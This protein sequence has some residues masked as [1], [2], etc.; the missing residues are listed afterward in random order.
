MSM[1]AI[2]SAKNMAVTMTGLSKDALHVYVGLIV[3]LTTALL[4][5]RRL[6]SLLP[7]L[8][9]VLA[10]TLGEAVDMRDDLRAIGYWQWR[11]SVHDF[12]NT[13]FWPTVLLVLAR[14]RQVLH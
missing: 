2:Q 7:W 9:V 14:F 5:R 13:L 12:I 1:S 3:L 8:A 10:A 11:A 4:L 6:S